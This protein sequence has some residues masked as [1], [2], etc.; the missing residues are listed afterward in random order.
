MGSDSKPE[1]IP[2]ENECHGESSCES[3]S[4]H[5]KS[6]D[7]D[8][9]SPGFTDPLSQDVAGQLCYF[10]ELVESATDGLFVLDEQGRFEYARSEER[11]VGK[12]CRSGLAPYH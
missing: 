7:M 5:F 10:R 8:Q 1:F 2:D 9:I 6:P 11:R 12:E 4:I 3:Q